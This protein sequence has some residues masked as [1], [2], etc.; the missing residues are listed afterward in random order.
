V[1]TTATNKR[2]RELLTE[3]RDGT[4]I[5]RPEFQRRLVWAL[6][7]KNAFIQTVLEGFPFPEIYIAAGNV[8]LST[9]AGTLM[10]VDGQQRLSTLYEYFHGSNELRLK[11]I[12]PYEKLSDKEKLNFLEYEVVV[13]DLGSLDIDQIKEVF[14]RIN[15]TSY[16]LNAMEIENA[17]YDG[18]FK[19][20]ADEL[21]QSSIF[22]DAKFFSPTEIRRMLDMRFVLSLMVTMMS[23]YFNRDEEIETYL[24][25]YN[26]EFPE[27]DAIRRRFNAVVSFIR[28]CRLE[29]SSRFWKKADFFT[30]FVEL[31]YLLNIKKIRLN[32]SAVKDALNTLYAEVDRVAD[33]DR[34]AEGDQGLSPEAVRYARAALQATNDRSNRL[35]RGTVV[36]ELLLKA[37]DSPMAAK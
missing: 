20:L 21:A 2:I 35:T 14:R 32:P 15:S 23:Q 7:H 19:R 24:Q 25:R 34:I 6:R 5:P 30:A 3:I 28:D 9:G 27:Y 13:R 29:S 1:K 36:R 8:D 4:L 37:A 12:P 26:D 17:R 33:V 18:E 11:D 16:S 10:L 31:D 22:E